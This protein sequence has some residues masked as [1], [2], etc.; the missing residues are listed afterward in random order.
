MIMGESPAV[1]AHRYA[2][3][4]DIDTQVLG[5]KNRAECVAAAETGPLPADLMAR[6]D[7]AVKAACP[8]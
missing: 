6:I 8:A 3:A 4:R 7:G 2:P 5:V 1:A